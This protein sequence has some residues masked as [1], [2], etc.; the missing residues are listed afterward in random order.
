M[1]LGGPGQQL[2]LVGLELV[3]V[4]VPLRHPWKSAAGT[5]SERESLLVRTVLRDH[6]GAP[7]G[8]EENEGWGEC[9]ALPWPTYNSEYTD[10]AL[11]V[12]R[13]YIVPALLAHAVASARSVAP[14]L[15]WLKGHNMLKSAFQMALL[16][17]E[18]RFSGQSLASYLASCSS[19]GHRRASTVRAG[20]V[21]GLTSSVGELLGQVENFVAEGYGRVKLKISPG[22]ELEAVAEVRNRWPQ[23]VVMV[24][25]NGA[26]AAGGPASAA[27][28]LAQLEEYDVACV[29]QPLA[30]DDFLGHAQLAQRVRVPICL[31]ESLTS[32]AAVTLALSVGACSVVNIKAG[33]LGGYL[34]AVRAHDICAATGA[35]T[36]CGGM[37]ETGLGRAANV[38]L[39]ALPNFSLP[40][41]I[42]A[43]S[44]FFEQDIAGPVE[45]G[46]DGTVTVPTGPG[47]GVE[48]LSRAMERFATVRLWQSRS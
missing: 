38:A 11:A 43:S 48:I 37:V 32:P 12:A 3:K 8:A 27:E 40:G 9:A 18:L 17:A 47:L 31:D 21:V 24:D 2:E 1:S 20:V 42:S 25:A 10:G 34:E 29:E 39:A 14:A 33:R 6:D 26:Y 46:A 5:L 44:R 23:L 28:Q 7:G 19:S 35:A 13:Q 4:I 15:D 45:L 16:D 41:D 30:A 22:R 36:W